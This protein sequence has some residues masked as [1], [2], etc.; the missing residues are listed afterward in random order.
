M[1]RLFQRLLLLVVAFVAAM[2]VAE[3]QPILRTPA[4][5]SD[6]MVLQEQASVKIW[7]WADPN[8]VVTVQ[9]SWM[10]EPVKT[11]SLYDTTWSVE[12][13]TPKA[14][15]EA[16]TIHIK[17][18][19]KAE[20]TINDVLI[21]QV[22]LCSGQSNM[23]W[24]AVRGVL[25]MRES[26]EKDQQYPAMRFFNVAKN[27]HRYTQYDCEGEWVICGHEHTQW[28]SGVGYFF[29]RHLY[30]NLQQPVG[31]INASW[32]G[33]P[34]EMWMY[35]EDVQKNKED[36]Q[37]FRTRYAK[38]VG[39]REGGMYN[40]MIRPLQNLRFSGVIWYQGCANSAYNPS[41]YAQQQA[42]LIARWRYMFGFEKMPFYFVQLAPHGKEAVLGGKTL[43][44]EQQAAVAAQ[45]P[46]TGMVNISDHVADVTNIHPPH[47]KPVGVRLGNWALAEVYKKEVGKYKQASMKSVE[48]KGGRAIITFD[49]AEGGIEC[50]GDAVAHLEIADA[51]MQFKP[52]MGMIDG[53]GRLLAWNKQ[54][55]KPV[56][57]RY[58]FNETAV[59]NLFDAAGMPVL[60][61][62]SDA[63][64]ITIVPST[65]KV[66]PAP[67][68]APKPAADAAKPAV[69][70][71]LMKTAV[72]VEGS[73]HTLLKL[74]NGTK[75]HPNRRYVLRNL[76]TD[77]V[78]FDFLQ[79]ASPEKG[80]PR[81]LH[82]T[83]VTAL[84][85]GEIYV[86]AAETN[87]IILK[88]L[89]KWKKLPKGR[90]TLDM[91]ADRQ[92]K[93]QIYA[94]PVKEGQTVT[95]PRTQ[96]FNDLS[97]IAVQIDYKE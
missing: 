38:R 75:L 34:I 27:S 71:G 94:L 60:P 10:A 15:N 52:A 54:V 53:E 41:A 2:S 88:A 1:K 9:P 62:R 70:A 22:W 46:Y 7:G 47:K 8:S 92:A 95:L 17:T 49:N 24:N 84:A 43:V 86:I 81:N 57:V 3:A 73:G 55:R 76:P 21:G 72:R 37:A 26:L 14:S 48:F 45:V 5:L 59:G 69:A 79:H 61:F 30:E 13:T 74:A 89:A 67:A 4:V 87:E 68:A 32:G 63:P 85:D 65:L 31:M 83:K 93:F 82:T 12:V 77:A 18:N 25:D 20:M 56:A 80:G 19:R 36:L 6:H 91:G 16:H 39:W 11:K 28:L 33:T 66:A 78:G 42:D 23:E 58:C 29:G 96:Q 35:H 51:S 64:E 90:V 50:R 44:R 40:A 97:L